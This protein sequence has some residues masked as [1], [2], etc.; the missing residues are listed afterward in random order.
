MAQKT[1]RIAVIAGDGIGPEVIGQAVR[2]V[3]TVCRRFDRK[4][5]LEHFDYGAERYLRDKV[6]LPAG[7][8]EQFR[9]EF[10]A[11][12]LGAVGDP[13][14]PGNE[15]ARDILLALRFELDLFANVRPVRLLDA[16]LTP[17][18]GRSAADIDFVVVRENTEGLYVNAGGVLHRG[19][20]DEVAV[21]EEITTCRGVERVT[22]FAF[23]LAR[24][25]KRRR[26]T[27]CDKS[28][29]LRYGHEL[30]QRVFR[31][32]AS[33]YPDLETDHYFVDTLAMVMVQNPGALDV[34]VTNNLFGDILTD[35]GAAIGG[36][37]GLAASASLGS[38]RIGLFEPVHGSAPNI[39]G[40]GIANP[41][42]AVLTVALLL[43]HLGWT[44]EAAAVETA[45]SRCVARRLTTPD[46]G[47]SASTEQVGDAIVAE[48]SEPQTMSGPRA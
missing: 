40:K 17:L 38:G 21:Q 14:I 32:V 7:A 34:V 2:V 4:V 25:Q 30:W 41:L 36:G 18:K 45:V 42:G 47:G 48:L 44:R 22:K 12:L 37:I 10:D 28:N 33:R 29:V 1:P 39:A 23:E 6:A 35:L 27:L 20:P 19:T 5:E 3:E 43:E 15:H 24:R 16:E 26:V 31:E 9:S 11:I 46:L 8:I 13:R